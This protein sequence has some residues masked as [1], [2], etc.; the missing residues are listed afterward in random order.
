MIYHRL[1]LRITDRCN[2]ACASC[3]LRCSP[4]G[5]RIMSRPMA[6]RLIDEARALDFDR[7]VTGTGSLTQV[8]RLTRSLS[9]G[10]CPRDSILNKPSA[11]N[12]SRYS[13]GV[14]WYLLRKE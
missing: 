3:G 4:S 7:R 10:T 6:E 2:A 13:A 11:E 1:E 8:P 9:Q 5:E 12:C 14:I